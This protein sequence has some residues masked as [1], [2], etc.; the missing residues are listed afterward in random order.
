M[1][2]VI[3]PERLLP[4]IVFLTALRML[5]HAFF[6]SASIILSD[7]AQNPMSTNALVD[8]RIVKPFLHLL[9]TLAEGS[10]PSTRPEGLSKMH[11]TCHSLHGAAKEA[12]L[13]SI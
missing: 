3:D 1:C 5:L 11:R 2:L 8:L 12:V 10:S 6:A 7:L 9:D 4:F 13:L